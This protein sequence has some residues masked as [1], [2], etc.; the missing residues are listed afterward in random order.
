MKVILLSSD[1]LMSALLEL[2]MSITLKDIFFLGLYT[3]ITF[4]LVRALHK[5]L[6][7]DIKEAN[8]AL[9]KF[10]MEYAS[11]IKL[12]AQMV[13]GGYAQMYAQPQRVREEEV[14]FMR[15]TTLKDL[16]IAYDLKSITIADKS[17]LLVESTIGDRERSEEEAA[18]AKEIL[19]GIQRTLVSAK[20][21]DIKVPGG[22]LMLGMV[23]RANACYI[24]RYAND[25]PES[26]RS[27]EA[28]FKA[29]DDYIIRKYGK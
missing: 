15:A 23:D 28:V 1:S 5:R 8:R 22:G 7:S 19:D 2:L 24:V 21:L 11:S 18:L 26:R 20:H 29:I 9:G 3:L 4:L 10:I 16:L 25:G 6:A 12:L 17:G 14:P 27:H 13:V